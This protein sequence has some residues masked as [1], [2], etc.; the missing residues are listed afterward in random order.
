MGLKQGSLTGHK[1]LCILAHPDDESLGTGGTIAKYSDEGSEVQ[2]ICATR[3]ERGR[4]YDQDSPG[5]VKVGQRRTEELL[6]AAKILGISKVH[7]LDYIDGDLDC[8]P[9]NEIVS[10]I[11]RIILEFR[12][13]VII[14]FGP[15]GG[16]GHPD[17]IAISQYSLSAIMQAATSYNVLKFYYLAWPKAHWELYLRAFKKLQMTVD[18]ELRESVP[19]PEWAI[20]TRIDTHRYWETVWKAIQCHQTQLPGYDNLTS[21]GAKEH[22]ELWGTQEF[23]RVFSLVNS[24][25]EIESDLFEGVLPHHLLE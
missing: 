12:P 14:T 20:T 5:F 18:N 6:S 25:R 15:D 4:Y 23:Y 21:L 1:L 3:G 9:V 8:S 19:W 13:Q 22:S 2:L 17:H 10:K 11:G 16:Y 7:F 24:G